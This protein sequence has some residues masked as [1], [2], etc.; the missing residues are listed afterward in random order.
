[1]TMKPSTEFRYILHLMDHFS[2]FHLI[3]PLAR[4]SAAEVN[5]ALIKM[6]GTIGL[7]HILQTDNGSEFAKL[8]DIFKGKINLYYQPMAYIKIALFCLV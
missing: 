6:F 1:M 2:K 3:S 8:G 4:K 5:C 7:P